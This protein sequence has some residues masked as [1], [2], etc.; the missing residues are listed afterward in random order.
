MISRRERDWMALGTGFKRS[1]EKKTKIH[2]NYVAIFFL[3]LKNVL[4]VVIMIANIFIIMIS[5]IC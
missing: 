3:V 4:I 5:N 1:K 2:F